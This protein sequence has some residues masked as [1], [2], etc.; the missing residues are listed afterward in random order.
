M[1]RI[2]GCLRSRE[3]GDVEASARSYH[4][5]GSVWESRVKTAGSKGASTRQPLRLT[6]IRSACWLFVLYVQGR[7]VVLWS[8]ALLFNGCVPAGLSA[9][10]EHGHVAFLLKTSLDLGRF[11][12]LLSIRHLK[13]LDS[14]ER[15]Y[16]LLNSDLEL[17]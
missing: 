2:R 9:S 7:S 14:R 11:E 10:A 16:F 13:P 15:G 4:V 17:T 8:V 5:T 3:S 12:G 1:H 6:S